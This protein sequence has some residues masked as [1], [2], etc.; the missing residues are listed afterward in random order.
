MTIQLGHSA[1]SILPVHEVDEGKAAALAS[2]A[3]VRDVDARDGTEG[4]EQFL[5]CTNSAVS[6]KLQSIVIKKLLY[7]AVMRD[8]YI[9]T[10]QD[11]LA[12]TGIL[13]SI[14]C[15]CV[16][17]DH[18]DQTMYC[19]SSEGVIRGSREASQGRE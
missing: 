9:V 18:R 14:T 3:V 5:Q 16:P 1:C 12:S 6:K 7:S 2:L 13:G 11:M 8:I 15:I 4:A 19:I 17:L 10:E